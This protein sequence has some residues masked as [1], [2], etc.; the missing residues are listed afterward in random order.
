M[1]EK[2]RSNNIYLANIDEIEKFREL[3]ER[4]CE[5]T[6]LGWDDSYDEDEAVESGYISYDE[7]F[8]DYTLTKDEPEQ[9]I[10]LNDL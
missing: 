1:K 7:E 2:L 4:N 3:L 5:D 10:T 9:F 6:V 8:D